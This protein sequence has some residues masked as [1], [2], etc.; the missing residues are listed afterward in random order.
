MISHIMKNKALSLQNCLFY[1]KKRL[2]LLFVIEHMPSNSLVMVG[3]IF[4]VSLHSLLLITSTH[5][6]LPSK[7]ASSF[8]SVMRSTDGGLHAGRG[9]FLHCKAAEAQRKT[10]MF[11]TEQSKKPGTLDVFLSTP[12]FKLQNTSSTDLTKPFFCLLLFLLYIAVL[13]PLYCSISPPHFTATSTSALIG[14]SSFY[15]TTS[16]LDILKV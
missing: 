13:Q 6:G 10:E 8:F 5:M 4:S 7:I 12:L 16:R 9:H 2:Y 14:Y 11:T 3:Y 1:T 15:V